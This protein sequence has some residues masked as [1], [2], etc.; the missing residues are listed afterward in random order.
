M[1]CSCA[2]ACASRHRRHPARTQA[3]ATGDGSDNRDR[4]R[5]DVRHAKDAQDYSDEKQLADDDA[6]ALQQ[7]QLAAAKSR[8]APVM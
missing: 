3:I 8:H 4:A 5:G 1:H 6:A 7:Q 2:S